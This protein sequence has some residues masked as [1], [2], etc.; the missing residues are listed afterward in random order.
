MNVR[1]VPA[2]SLRVYQVETT[3]RCDAACAYCPQPAHARARGRIT[4][5]TFLAALAAMSNR[6]VSLHHFGEPLLLH[7][8]EDL[9]KLAAVRG[10]DVGFSTNG[11]LLTQERLNRLADNGLRYLRLHTDPFGVRLASFR[12]PAQVEMTEHRLEA[13]NDAPQKGKVSFSGAVPGAPPRMSGAQ[14]CSFIKDRWVVALWN[15]DIALCCHDVEGSNDPNLCSA[16]EGYVFESPR[17]WG[18]Y[19]GR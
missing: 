11:R 19:D 10:F 8:L 12:V 2:Q 9:V 1:D 13:A 7:D 16:C 14:R 6:V 3:N 4:K 18:D 15:G 17:D 5:E